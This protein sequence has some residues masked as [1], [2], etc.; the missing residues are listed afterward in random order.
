M[1]RATN[2]ARVRRILLYFAAGISLLLLIATIV[3]WWRSYGKGKLTLGD[4]DSISFTH[5][6]PVYWV[7]MYPGEAVFCRQTGREWD[8][9]D[10]AHFHFLGIE[11][12]GS[13]GPTGDM[14][15][16]LHVPFWM[17]TV[18]TAVLPVIGLW[19]WRQERKRR[20]RERAGCCP[21]CG[22]DLRAT[23]TRCPECGH[24]PRAALA[25]KEA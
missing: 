11:F 17:L 3:F 10:L 14:L 12:G 15:W 21:R 5:D 19:S 25:M 18:L 9:R 6:D 16:N 7:I 13:Q 23:P 20:R 24:E 4:R 2:L 22:Y 1:P 8:G